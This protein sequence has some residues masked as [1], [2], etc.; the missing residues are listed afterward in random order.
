MQPHQ[1]GVQSKYPR[2]R[3]TTDAMENLPIRVRRMRRSLEQCRSRP[4][5][6]EIVRRELE[7]VELYFAPI[8]IRQVDGN[9]E[10]LKKRVSLL[11][12][13]DT[14]LKKHFRWRP[15]HPVYLRY[16]W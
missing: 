4:R 12:P 11:W 10:S 1:C 8:S 3:C 9:P 7:P 13:R 14:A 6:P 15:D 2:D 5:R 16:A